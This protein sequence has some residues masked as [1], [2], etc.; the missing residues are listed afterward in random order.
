[1][2]LDNKADCIGGSW[3]TGIWWMLHWHEVNLAIYPMGWAA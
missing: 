1:M 2:K 3:H